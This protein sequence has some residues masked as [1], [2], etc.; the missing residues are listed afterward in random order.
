MSETKKHI[1]AIGAHTGDVQLTCGKT[2]AKHALLG[3]MIT[4][5]DV[6]AGERGAPSNMSVEDFKQM[7]INSA[8]EFAKML[9]GQS[10]VLNYRD[11]EVPENEDIK[12]EIADLIRQEKPDVILT[13][14]AK[15]TH[16]D[17]SAVHRVVN[18]A[19]FYGALRTMERELPSHWARGPYFA[20][21]WEDAQDFVPYIYVDVTEGYDLWVEA[22]KKL[23]LTNNSPWFQYL[24]Y[25][26]A[27]S[28][29]RGTLIHK[30][31]AECYMVNP[32]N[33]KRVIDSF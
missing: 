17:H 31:R 12:F 8:A 9:N 20:E 26:D 5:V 2:L 21:N 1:M 29:A 33:M 22:I 16:K 25:Y 19:I 28:R 24:E 3:D 18:D 4:T 10:I 30:K 6:T 13:H 11:A 15:S 27:L 32:Q 14:W 7:N 23:W